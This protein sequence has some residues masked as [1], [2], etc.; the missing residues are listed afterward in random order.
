MIIWAGAAGKLSFA[1]EFLVDELALYRLVGSPEIMA[2]QKHCLAE[3]A[4]MPHVT[5]QI[6]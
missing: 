1:A 4:K 5:V 6:Y 2:G 3:V